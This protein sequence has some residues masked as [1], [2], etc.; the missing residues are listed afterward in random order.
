MCKGTKSLRLTKEFFTF[1][2]KKN[3]ACIPAG[4]ALVLTNN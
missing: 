3:E 2:G 1:L 4:L